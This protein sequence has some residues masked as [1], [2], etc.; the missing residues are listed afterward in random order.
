MASI[1]ACGLSGVN[2]Q[3]FSDEDVQARKLLVKWASELGLRIFS[4]AIG[5]LFLRYEPKGS[6]GAPVLSGSHMD[7]QPCGGRFDGT[8]GVLAALEAVTALHASGAQLRRPVDVVCWSNEEGSRFAPGA[9]GSMVFTGTRSLEEFLD[10]RDRAGIYLRDALGQTLD[11]IPQAQRCPIGFSAYAYVEVHIEQGAVLEQAGKRIGVVTGIQGCRWFEV[12]VTGEARHAGTTPMRA[13]K[14]ALQSAVRMI[15]ALREHFADAQDHV[16]FTVGRFDTL[17]N[18]PNTVPEHVRFTIDLRHP[19]D[20]E[21]ARL[22]GSIC[23]IAQ[24]AGAPCGVTVRATFVC[25]PVQF[26]KRITQHVAD[27]AG[28]L[29][30]EALHMPSGA[31]HD[32]M[33][34]AAHCPTGMIFVPSARG[35]SHHPDEYTASADLAAGARV[36]AEVLQKLA[37]E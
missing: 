25:D 10:I 4:D 35:I 20:A 3:A 28:A 16:R 32:A 26:R 29:G 14:D 7:S 17:P 33:F 27:A 36:L 2:R 31:F 30:L 5:N 24:T 12:E 8:Y 21:L 37:T 1:G 9:M 13:R 23:S 18:S 6:T 34:L 22:A 19:E 15:L 11:A